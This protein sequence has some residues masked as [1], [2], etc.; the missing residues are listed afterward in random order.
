MK[1]LVVLGSTGS[2]GEQTLA[3]VAAFPERYRVVALAAGRN[4]EKLA[5][6][7]RRVRPVMNDRRV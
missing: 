7:V 4:V 2:I 3:V 5:D 1:R 6:Q